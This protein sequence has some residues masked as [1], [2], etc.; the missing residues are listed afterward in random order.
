MSFRMKVSDL[1]RINEKT[2]FVGD[3][4]TN[5]KVIS[6]VRCAIEID[7]SKVGWLH[8]SGE[9]HTG[10]PHRDLW[11]TS[12]VDLSREMIS[13][14]DVWLVSCDPAHER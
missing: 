6:N 9:V 1:F 5:D 3:V 10:K 4:K 12:P 8:I 13:E 11:T 14:H 7:G 2:V